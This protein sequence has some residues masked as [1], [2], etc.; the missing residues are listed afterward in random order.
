MARNSFLV[1]AI[2][3]RRLIRPKVNLAPEVVNIAAATYLLSGSDLG[4]VLDVSSTCAITI[5]NSTFSSQ[6]QILLLQ[7]GTGTV[8]FTAESGLTLL[9]YPL[10]GLAQIP[11][12]WQYVV[13]RFL[14]P[15]LC[16]VTKILPTYTMTI[17]DQAAGTGLIQGRTPDTTS[18]GTT[19]TN[20]NADAT[21]SAFNGYFGA[22]NSAAANS[23][24][25]AV[26]AYPEAK[27]IKIT[28]GMQWRLTSTTIPIGIFF[29][30]IDANNYREVTQTRDGTV[31]LRTIVAGAVTVVATGAAPSTNI[32]T[33]VT[34]VLELSA[35]GAVYRFGGT[36]YI[37]YTAENFANINRVAG[38]RTRAAV[39]RVL[40]WRLE[41]LR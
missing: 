41:I 19:W 27:A 35:S 28:Q 21:V 7:S 6:D 3:H 10:G 39:D 38:F 8:S 23:S 32:N 20:V 17:Q 29:D 37:T 31:Q 40:N 14:S 34:G 9:T 18:A 2:A 25:F 33:T 26:I 4:K 24:F 1:P 5:P 15:T 36:A 11:G 16:V 12:R 30:Y 22:T 13:L